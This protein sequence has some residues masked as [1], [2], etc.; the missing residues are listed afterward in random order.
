MI[1]F[2]DREVNCVILDGLTRGWLFSYFLHENRDDLLCVTDENGRCLGS[3][4]YAS[5]LESNDVEESIRTEK[6]VLDRQIWE[7]GRKLFYRYRQQADEIILIPVVNQDGQLIC[8][9][10]QDE[11]ANREIRQL[12]ELAECRHKLDFQDIFPEYDCVTIWECNELAYYFAEYLQETGLPVSVKGGMWDIFGKWEDC[13]S[14]DYRNLNIYAEGTWNKSANLRE[15]ALRSVSV[16]FECI[17]KVYETNIQEGWIKDGKGTLESFL[18][19]LKK[20]KELFLIGTG[21]ETQ[22]TYDFLLSHGIDITGFITDKQNEQRKMILGKPIYTWCGMPDSEHSVII[23]CTQKHSAW[24]FGEVDFYDYIGYYR[25]D[26]YFLIKDYCENTKRSLLW[27]VLSGR[28]II[29]LGD[30]RLCSKISVF[31]KGRAECFYCD[32]MDEGNILEGCKTLLAREIT[33]TDICVPVFLENFVPKNSSAEVKKKKECIVKMRES[34][35]RE[36]G[37]THYTDYFYDIVS[38]IELEQRTA[39]NEGDYAPKG[40]CIGAISYCCGNEFF[41]GVMEGHPQILMMD[42]CYLNDNL[43][44]ICL[45]LSAEK[46]ENMAY[47]FWKIIDSESANVQKQF[48][49]RK[50][51]GQRLEYEL[52]KKDYFTSQEL[53]V[54]LHLA[55]ASMWNNAPDDI[56]DTVIY[57]EPHLVLRDVCERYAGWLHAEHVSGYILNLVRNGSVRA[58][59]YLRFYEYTGRL[60]DLK[61]VAY[62]RMVDEAEPHNEIYNG[63]KRIIVKFEDLKCKSKEMLEYLCCEL[64]I[65]WSDTFLQTTC[66]GGIIDCRGISGFDLKPVYNTYEKYFSGYDRMRL[67]LLLQDWQEEYGYPVVDIRTFSRRELQEMFVKNFRFEDMYRF[68]DGIDLWK[69]KIQKMSWVRRRIQRLICKAYV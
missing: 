57:W 47:A 49:D 3:I 62:W 28:R 18:L 54:I 9:A 26:R 63:Y 22:D 30:I 68:W 23:E 12:R 21:P 60:L 32:F 7:N 46:R 6:L 48:P 27:H 61:M 31:L 33:A 64:G 65:R 37:I 55:Y 5:L 44:S 35:M 50:R 67:M 58:G 59:S 10:Y 45:C 19:R 8:F 16:E 13:E 52:Q 69:Y 2:C 53:F 4:T 25:N 42:S 66:H 36:Y 51:F 17:D 38:F 1:R 40:I 56:L 43:F 14:L 29:L 34:K 15:L 39:W 20:E 41:R 11:D 24:G